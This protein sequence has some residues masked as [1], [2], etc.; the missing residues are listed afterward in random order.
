M[1]LYILKPVVWNSAGYQRPSG[2]KTATGY[3][4]KYGYGH[5]EW[6]NSEA[7]TFLEN[8]IKQKVFHTEGVGNQ[9]VD[10]HAG[11]IFIFLIASNS[12]SQYLIGAAGNA[13][14]L[15]GPKQKARR[16]EI[17]RKLN[18]GDQFRKDA[19]S[20]AQVQKSFNDDERRFERHWKSDEHWI[21]N[22]ICQAEDYVA[23]P[24]PIKL[25][26]QAITGRNNLVRMFGSY[27][28]ISRQTA[29]KI[30]DLLPSTLSTVDGLKAACTNE[31]D[32]K[33]D[34]EELDVIPS[35]TTRK[36]LIE[37]R[38][39]TGKYR[40]QLLAKWGGKCALS[41]CGVE[42]IIR[43]SHIKPWRD[44]KNIERLDANN[45][46]PLVAHLDALFDRGLIT[47]DGDGGLVVSDII[48]GDQR[49]ILRLEGSLRQ[50]VGLQTAAYL[51][52]HRKRVFRT[53]NSDA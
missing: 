49:N 42:E 12:G 47:F 15:T 9:P 39:G 53:K 51:D 7:L 50:N 38:L 32:V 21:P 25:D 2:A 45:G 22:W 17:V 28:S 24:T 5:E 13:T 43:A 40:K 31:S 18:V 27:H 35:A 34:L 19:W 20:L 29:L 44:S 30:L 48:E 23:L 26:P 37:A 10:E 3:T 4:K 41:G 33:E 11:N 8:G 36:A 1:A 14:A 46:L 52:W 16:S 6:N